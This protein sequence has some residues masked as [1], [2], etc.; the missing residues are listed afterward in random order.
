MSRTRAQNLIAQGIAAAKA[1]EM[2][3]ARLVFRQAVEIDPT[4]PDAWLWHAGVVENPQHAVQALERVLALDPTNKRAKESLIVGRLEAGIQAAQANRRI[5]ARSLLLQVTVD[6]PTNESAWLWLA[7]ATD[8]PHEAIGCLERAL[9]LNP[10]NDR[11]RAGIEVFRERVKAATQWFCPICQACEETRFATCPQCRAILELARGDAAIDNPSPNT[12][13]IRQGAIRLASEAKQKGDFVS[14]YYL[15]M[16]L[17]NLAKPDEALPHFRSALAL[18]AGDA[19]MAAQVSTLEQALADAPPPTVRISAA[20]REKHQQAQD[21][22]GSARKSILVVDDSPTIRKLVGITMRKRGYRVL[23]A[24]DGREA[25]E[26]MQVEG[27]PD[28]LVLDVTMPRMD[29]YMLC[30]A[31]RD[32]LATSRIPVIMLSDRDG[33]LDRMRGRMAGSNQYLIKPFQ[34]EVFVNAVRDHCPLDG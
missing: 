32:N 8:D 26:V 1:G 11:A 13:K 6:D 19:G 16:A 10:A 33:F 17:L 28:L 20:D 2:S 25:L 23:E 30:R 24:G 15:G 22:F 21:R 9:Q 7:G 27:N 12:A 18:S 34:P 29:G 4:Y 3:R 14:Y 31:I 5:E